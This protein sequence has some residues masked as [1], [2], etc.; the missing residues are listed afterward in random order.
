MAYLTGVTIILATCAF[1]KKGNTMNKINRMAVIAGGLL[2]SGGLIAGLASAAVDAHDRKHNHKEH[3]GKHFKSKKIDINKD[4]SISLEELLSGNM[5]RFQK[6]DS[7]SD[8][9]L[10]ADE[11]NARLVAM[12]S[13][14]DA[15]GDG[16][17]NGDEMPKRHKGHRK[18]GDRGHKHNNDDAK[19]ATLP[20]T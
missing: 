1:A 3:M 15:N 20:A 11:F 19:P 5:E 18:H 8:G 9:T 2:L 6:L 16:L 14:I 7:D 4:G 12:F 17:I 13:K 10:S